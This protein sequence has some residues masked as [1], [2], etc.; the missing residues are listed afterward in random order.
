MFNLL[1]FV[2]LEDIVQPFNSSIGGA[3]SNF[4][5]ASRPRPANKVFPPPSIPRGY[6]PFL[7]VKESNER[8]PNQA[9]TQKHSS[10]HLTSSERGKLLG[11]EPLP[12]PIKSVFEYMSK[13][14]KDRL[15]FMNSSRVARSSVGKTTISTEPLLSQKVSFIGPSGFQPFAKDPAKQARYESFLESR[16]SGKVANLP[17]ELWFV[18]MIL[19][20][21]L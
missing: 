4:S 18:L 17:K 7:S 8:K 20:L 2:Q 6:Q 11:E 1:I 9:E 16:K 12:K 13:S 19:L 5:P 10:L 21:L 15:E 14:D 3:L